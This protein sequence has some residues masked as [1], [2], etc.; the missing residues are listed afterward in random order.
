MQATVRHIN[1]M[2]FIANADSNHAVIMDTT[3]GDGSASSPLEYMLM[4]LGGCSAIDVVLILQKKRIAYD[5]FEV[6]LNTTRRDE[7]PRIFTSIELDYHFSDDN[8][9]ASRKHIEDAVRLSEEKYCSVAG[10]LSPDVK[11]TWQVTIE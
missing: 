11:L 2:R 1:N 4:S 6:R 5:P 8:L 9:E 7:P 3:S 10:M